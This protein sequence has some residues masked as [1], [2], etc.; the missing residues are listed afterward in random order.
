MYLP[1][2]LSPS[3]RDPLE[4]IKWSVD[5]V[6]K[7]ALLEVIFS[8]VSNARRVQRNFSGKR[9][10]PLSSDKNEFAVRQEEDR[11]GGK[12]KEKKKKK[13]KEKR[14]EVSR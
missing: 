5:S 11:R 10:L 1:T 4:T 7:D 13:K 6:F 14:K 2:F 8:S 9:D 3:I 12:E